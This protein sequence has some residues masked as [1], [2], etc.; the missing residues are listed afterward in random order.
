MDGVAW[1]SVSVPRARA[2]THQKRHGLTSLTMSMYVMI[3]GL[4][5]VGVGWLSVCRGVCWK[6]ME[7]GK[8]W[9]EL[10][11]M[12]SGR[13]RQGRHTKGGGRAQGLQAKAR[14]GHNNSTRSRSGQGRG[15]R[16]AGGRLWLPVTVCGCVCVWVDGL[17]GVLRRKLGWRPP[18]ARA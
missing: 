6:G 10:K 5:L 14:G 3:A 2:Q 18:E 13:R 4:G 12:A 17:S 16:Q 15:R 8:N 9:E 11:W 7:T 1:T